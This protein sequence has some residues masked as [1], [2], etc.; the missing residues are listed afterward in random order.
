MSTYRMWQETVKVT[1]N[2][3][4]HVQSANALEVG[5]FSMAKIILY[6]HY[7]SG[8][9]TL[10]IETGVLDCDKYYRD[11]GSWSAIASPSSPG[12]LKD[13]VVLKAETATG[14]NCMERFIRWKASGTSAWELTLELHVLGYEK[15]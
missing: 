12:D 13:P 15:S 5:L 9:P 10:T 14:S 11:S 7:A 4:T 6:V 8:T 2:S 3:S 1:G